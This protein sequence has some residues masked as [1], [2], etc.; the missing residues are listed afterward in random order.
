VPAVRDSVAVAIYKGDVAVV[1]QLLTD[2]CDVDSA[3]DDNRAIVRAS[4]YGHVSVV[5][6]LLQDKRVGPAAHFPAD[7][8]ILA[9]QPRFCACCEQALAL[10]EELADSWRLHGAGAGVSPEVMDDIAWPLCFGSR[11]PLWMRLNCHHQYQPSSG[12]SSTVGCYS[13][14]AL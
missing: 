2:G 13:P 12:S 11:L 7:S 1:N 6:R 9:W 14:S 3:A 8:C 10:A 4:M 5:D